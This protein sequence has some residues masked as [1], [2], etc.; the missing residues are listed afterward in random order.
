MTRYCRPSCRTLR[1]MTRHDSFIGLNGALDCHIVSWT[2]LIWRDTPKRFAMPY[3]RHRYA[4]VFFAVFLCFG[5]PALAAPLGKPPNAPAL[6]EDPEARAH[7]KAGSEYFK[8]GDYREA[9]DEFRKAMALKKTRA[10]MGSVASSLR[11]LSIIG[12]VLTI[13]LLACYKSN[14]WCRPK[15]NLVCG[16]CVANYSPAG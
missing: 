11:Q 15:L 16:N 7:F 10:V 8:N 2:R 14:A 9:Y 5:E 1:G 13:V 12:N 6:P 4:F 3:H